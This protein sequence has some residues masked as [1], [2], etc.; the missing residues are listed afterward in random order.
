MIILIFSFSTDLGNEGSLE[1]HL[2]VHTL[3]SLMWLHILGVLN[4]FI[5]SFIFN[6]I[7][8]IERTVSESYSGYPMGLLF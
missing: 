2:G 5:A 8:N 1:A 6:L 4:I 7:D 3:L